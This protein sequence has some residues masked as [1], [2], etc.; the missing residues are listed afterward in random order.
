MYDLLHLFYINSLFLYFI[1]INIRIFLNKKWYM[2]S[3]LSL[4]LLLLYI[5][6]CNLIQNDKHFCF[7]STICII[8]T[9]INL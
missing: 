2:M 8:K 7:R 1:L 4:Y 6:L 9:N 5:L 3:K